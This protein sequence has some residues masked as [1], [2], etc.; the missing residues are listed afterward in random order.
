[1][2]FEFQHTESKPQRQKGSGYGALFNLDAVPLWK[3]EEGTHTVRL[4]PPN[5]GKSPS[6]GIP[7]AF[8]YGVPDPTTHE[9][10]TWL[11]LREMRGHKKCPACEIFFDLH[12]QDRNH[13]LKPK[14]K[15]TRKVFTRLIVRG[16]N[17]TKPLLWMMTP[18][19]N[20]DIKS[21]AAEKGIVRPDHPFEGIDVRV[22]KEGKGL[23]T[24]YTMR[25]LSGEQGPILDDP[26]A[27]EA[28]LETIRTHPLGSLL[29]LLDK[30]QEA[31]LKASFEE[32]SS[33]VEETTDG[34]T[35][36]LF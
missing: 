2:D 6:W 10:H 7:I 17:E 8:H 24:R 1:M 5:P 29:V 21:D 34:Q 31:E 13:P 3:M 32:D 12:K 11:C 36:P 14:F 9:E 25:G 22:K 33:D 18:S 27:T 4:L 23:N 19:I 15:A 28:I 16:E 26:E 20:D 35:E 30:E